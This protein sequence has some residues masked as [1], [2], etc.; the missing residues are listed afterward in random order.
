[1]S[2]NPSS[3][4]NT[5]R[6][7]EAE[8]VDRMDSFVSNTSGTNSSFN[9][10]GNSDTCQS[11]Y[12]RYLYV[13]ALPVMIFFCVLSIFVNVII[14]VSA[15]W[16]RRPMTPTLYFSISLAL[17]DA[18]ASIALATGLIVNSLLPCV[19][20]IKIVPPHP[21]C[22]TLVIE[23]F[24]LGCILITVKHLLALGINHW[25]GIVRPLHYAAT[26]TR[27][28]AWLVIVISWASP[29]LLLFAYFSVHPGQGFLIEDCR[30]VSIFNEK[31]FRA[32][33]ASLFFAPLL[34]MSM[35]YLH[36][37]LIV[38]STHQH[39]LRYQVKTPLLLKNISSFTFYK[40]QYF[41]PAPTVLTIILVLYGNY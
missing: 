6:G 28:T 40:E 1:M 16:C 26:M 41:L 19:F 14:V 3:S 20:N 27:R 31:T 10:T 37:F 11:E 39:R 36:I 13:Y 17:A 38:K 24:R 15:R 12:L 7:H 25:I 22:V 23:I 34:V 8:E 9:S 2:A 4:N 32:I 18:A 29:V 35:I 5:L 30:I 33:F 21:N